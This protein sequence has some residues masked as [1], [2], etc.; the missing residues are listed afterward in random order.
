[1]GKF[2]PSVSH[3][4]A[5]QRLTPYTAFATVLKQYSPRLPHCRAAGNDIVAKQNSFSP[6][7]NLPFQPVN[8]LY[9]FPSLS[10]RQLMLDSVP[11]G[12]S[13]ALT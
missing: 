4:L 2:Q 12:F 3:F 13:K 11:F 7:V 9:I 6:N 8:P 1:M 5:R 10:K